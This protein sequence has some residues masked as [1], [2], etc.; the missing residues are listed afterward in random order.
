LPFG[1]VRIRN[2]VQS[3]VRVDRLDLVGQFDVGKLGP[4]DYLFLFLDR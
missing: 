1:A 4:A 3:D 2:G